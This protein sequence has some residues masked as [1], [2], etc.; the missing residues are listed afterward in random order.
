MKNKFIATLLIIF[1]FLMSGR[2][3]HAKEFI[4]NTESIEIL[5]N[6]T[7]IKAKNGV[8]QSPEDQIEINSDIFYLDKATSILKAGKGNILL[9]KSDI[10]IEADE[11]IYN[12]NLSNLFANGNVKL[13][14]NKKKIFL[15][16]EK[17]FFSKKSQIIES[18]TKTTIRDNFG[19]IFNVESFKY[20]LNDG[21]I[22]LNKAELTD[23]NGNL[24]NLEKAY[25]NL[26]TKKLIG[27]DMSMIFNKNYLQLDGEPRIKG[28][29]IS[30]DEDKTVVKGGVFTSCKKNDD[31][32]PW[33]FL[34]KE[35]KHDKKKKTIHY[36]NAWLKIY[37]VPIVY[38]PKFFHPDPTVKRQSG[39]LMPSFS[40]SSSVGSS[41]NVPYYKVFSE[42]SDM[43]I[44]PRFFSNDKLITQAEY[45]VVNSD[46]RYNIESS[47]FSKM[48]SPA[49]SHI[50]IDGFKELNFSSFDESNLNFKL[51]T[52]SNDTY[53][54]T[55]KIDSNI[56]NDETFLT[57]SL[58][59]NAYRDD[60][61]FKGGIA[62]Y[63]DLNKLDNDKFEFIYPTFNL[64]KK[65][66][67][68]IEMNVPGNFTINTLGFIKNYETNIFEEV[69]I[70]DLSFDSDSIFTKN[71]LKNDYKILIKNTNTKGKNSD[72]Y[73]SFNNKIASL[74]QI[75]TSYP[76]RKNN[77]NFRNII[78]PTASF[79][80]SPNQNN[81]SLRKKDNRI[82]I[83]NIHSI[84]RIA[85]NDMVEGGAS[86]TYGFEYKKY[87][88]KNDQEIFNSKFANIIRLK[89]NRNLPTNNDIGGK[90]SDFFGNLNY[91]PNNMFKIGYDF[92]IDN[93]LQDT[94]YQS[95]KTD[96]TVNNFVTSFEYVNE[97]NTLNASS[98]INSKT[99]YNFDKATNMSFE[100]RVNKKT[101]MTEFYNLMYQYRNDCL[102][103][104]LE[105]NKD[106]YTDRDLN[107]E[108]NIFFKLSIIPFGEITSPSLR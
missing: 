96:M 45:R 92:V 1:L 101:K 13:T 12:K 38:F 64:N 11:I 106:Y 89:E 32:P 40:N 18:S 51:E 107:P 65:I 67:T 42:N 103:A 104:S 39:F 99:S 8:V 69:L 68:P 74:L 105:Y 93:N 37:D 54:K 102:I 35:I 90:T 108:E 36:K 72:K 29:T 27:K 71:G 10:K 62:A 7:L 2:I 60:L 41:L 66:K 5:K 58:D 98:Y 76:L 55:Y 26:N 33:Q 20:T 15:I 17:I 84:N 14:D 22:K 75:N 97:N 86:L 57:S 46:S 61:S 87:H 28:N 82:E 56:N 23:I 88:A 81:E 34:A 95:I 94:K 44:K 43:T 53:L 73:G 50:F 52:I 49:K 78:K 4:F 3:I 21:L 16:S 80:Y 24:F 9:F 48:G 85:S 59:F 30:Y 63:E 19:N 47:L 70:N 77:E 100:T 91:M 83:N 79:K 6:G 31:C 25:L